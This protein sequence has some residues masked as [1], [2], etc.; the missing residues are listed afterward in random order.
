MSHANPTPLRVGA[1]GSLHGWQVRVAGRLVLGVEIAGET[2]YWN[3]FHLVGDNGNLGTIVFEETEQSPEWKLF[4][5]FQAI[6]AMSAP[7]AAAKR[8]GDTVNLDG[9]PT[10]ITLVDESRVYHIEGEAPEGV[11]VGDVARYFNADRGQR[12]LVASWTGDEIEFYEGQ[13]VPATLVAQTFG[14]P[15]PARAS[16][17]SAASSLRGDTTSRPSSATIGKV[18]AVLVLVGLVAAAVIWFLSNRS[19]RATSGRLAAPPTLRLATGAHGR[20][21]TEEFTIAGR[22]EVEIAR[23]RGRTRRHEYQ[24]R[25]ANNETALLVTGLTGAPQEWHLLRPIQL[26]TPRDPY[27]AAALRK[28]ARLDDAGRMAIVSELFR[29]STVATDGVTDALPAPQRVRYGWIAQRSGDWIIARWEES[30]LQFHSAIPIAESE[31]RTAFTTA[32][33]PASPK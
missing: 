16:T 23:L 25:G 5:E 9:T 27:E 7:E 32:A 21:G 22:A 18:I 33:A 2:Y 1:R 11:S 12:M 29:S 28:S 8:V 15:T 3:E 19:P 20:L 10:R 26:A 4:R 31:I 24:L 30:Q 13:D 17:S 6:R 14:F